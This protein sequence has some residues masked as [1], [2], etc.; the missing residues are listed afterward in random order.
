MWSFSVSAVLRWFNLWWI[1]CQR[2]LMVQWI[3]DMLLLSFQILRSVNK[4]YSSANE[5]H[6]EDKSC[7]P[8]L[9]RHCYWI[10]MKMLICRL[11]L[12]LGSDISKTDQWQRFTGINQT[13][14]LYFTKESY[15]IPVTTSTEPKSLVCIIG[16]R[17]PTGNDR[18]PSPR[19]GFVA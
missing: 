18:R 1:V 19:N 16:S 2:L 11:E 15:S 14:V 4:Q 5:R 9:Y 12:I 7:L 3:T 13:L 10:Q 8:L 17:V 6:F